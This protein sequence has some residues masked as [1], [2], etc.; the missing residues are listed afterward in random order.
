MKATI[1]FGTLIIVSSLTSSVSG[2]A[3]RSPFASRVRWSIATCP[4]VRLTRQ[5]IRWRIGY[6]RPQSARR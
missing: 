6:K 2:P 3:T 4:I 1:E 5:K